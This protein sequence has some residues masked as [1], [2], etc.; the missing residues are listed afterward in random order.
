MATSRLLSQ[1]TIFPERLIAGGFG[2]EAGVV[3]PRCVRGQSLRSLAPGRNRGSHPRGPYPA[4]PAIAGQTQAPR[5]TLKFQDWAGCAPRPRATAHERRLTPDASRFF[6]AQGQPL[7]QPNPE[8]KLFIGGAY[9]PPSASPPL[10]PPLSMPPSG[11]ARRV[12]L[13]QVLHRAR[14]RRL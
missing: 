2:S 1:R 4:R 3:E 5:R 13:L 12:P 11:D 7:A 14:M 10:P 8:N 9:R 6:R